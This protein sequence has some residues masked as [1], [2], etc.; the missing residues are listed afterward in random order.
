MRIA[1]TACRRFGKG[2]GHPTR[3]DLGDCYAYALVR[4]LGEPLLFKG[5]D[6]SQMDIEMVTEAI[7]RHRLSEVLAGYG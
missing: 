7:K 3:L 6:F 5:S 2:S 4:K 1:R